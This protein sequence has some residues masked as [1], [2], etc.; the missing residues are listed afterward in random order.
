M[1][2]MMTLKYKHSSN[3]NEW[4]SEDIFK[5]HWE[6]NILVKWKPLS[7]SEADCKDFLQPR[8]GLLELH[9]STHKQNTSTP[10]S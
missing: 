6:K 8:K 10:S 9:P 1:L 7:D 5:I 4:K 3:R 2:M